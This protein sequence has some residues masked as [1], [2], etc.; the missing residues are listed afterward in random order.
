MDLVMVYYLLVLTYTADSRLYRM[1]SYVNTYTIF[2]LS[3]I[4][5]S[6]D[7]E[8]ASIH[9]RKMLAVFYQLC[10]SAQRYMES[11]GLK[12]ADESASYTFSCCSITLSRKTS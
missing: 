6:G 3:Y 11:S 7:M 5:L 4:Q 9:E 2:T 8:E 1:C 12:Q 10:A